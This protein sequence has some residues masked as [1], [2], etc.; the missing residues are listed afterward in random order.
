VASERWKKQ[1]NEIYTT[2]LG[3]VPDAFADVLESAYRAGLERAGEIASE[4][5]KAT[6]ECPEMP[7][8]IADAIRKEAGQ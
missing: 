1:A 7:Q 6:G 4:V 3:S 2:C 5:G 8:H